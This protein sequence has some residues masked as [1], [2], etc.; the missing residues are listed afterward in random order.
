MKIIIVLF[1]IYLFMILPRMFNKPDRK[2]FMGYHY[3]HRG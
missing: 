3:A 1:L 2:P